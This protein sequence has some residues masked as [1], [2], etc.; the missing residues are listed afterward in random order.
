MAEQY[1][2]DNFAHFGDGNTSLV[3]GRRKYKGEDGISYW[4]FKFRPNK[5]IISIYQLH[6]EINPIDGTVIRTYPY[7]EVEVVDDNP[8]HL[9]IWIFTDFDG[10][11]T[12]VSKQDE[13]KD[14]QILNHQ[15][16][17]ALLELELSELFVMLKKRTT[18]E[19]YV[20]QATEIVKR[21][22]GAAAKIDEDDEKK[23]E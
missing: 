12:P 9:R 11:Q 10:N 7:T 14:M 20:S 15:R 16:K 23:G 22:R 6:D 2:L 18:P 19:E 5:R 13:D 17:I 3:L 21:A 8:N 1:Q 4:E